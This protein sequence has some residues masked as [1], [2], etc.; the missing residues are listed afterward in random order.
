LL[1]FSESKIGMMQG[2]LSPQYL[3]RIQSFPV[4]N[5]EQELHDCKNLG[6][7]LVE[8]TIDEIFYDQNPIVSKTGTNHINE[9]LAELDLRVPSIT[10]DY[11]MEKPFWGQD[12]NKTYGKL[13]TIIEGMINIGAQLLVIPLVDNASIN[14][15]HGYQA[16]IFQK[17]L[18]DYEKETIFVVFETDLNPRKCKEFISEFDP[19]HFGINYDIGNSA[20]LGYDVDEEFREYGDRILNVHVK[21]REFNGNT[22]P[23]GDGA[24]NF[25]AVVRNLRA[26]NYQGNYILQT[27]RAGD[28][29]HIEAIQKY[30]S[31]WMEQLTI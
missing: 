25:Q 29:A 9:I 28:N 14:N 18:Q 22:V 17:L 7:E 4:N 5:W 27:A 21:D 11:F 16:E 13:K 15:T 26:L 1:A 6:I 24:A 31:F 2:R 30:R 23:L 19:K 8:W 12:G 3:G 10:C 20:S